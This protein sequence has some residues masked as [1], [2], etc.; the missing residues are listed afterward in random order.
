MKLHVQM[1]CL[2]GMM[3]VVLHWLH[4]VWVWLINWMIEWVVFIF[5]HFSSFCF[6]SSYFHY[7]LTLRLV[8]RCDWLIWHRLYQ[9]IIISPPKLSFHHPIF[10]WFYTATLQ[11]STSS[12]L[13]FI[14]SPHF[15]LWFLIFIFLH[16][17]YSY[18]HATPSNYQLSTTP[19]N[20]LWMSVKTKLPSKPTPL[21]TLISI[22]SVS[23]WKRTTS[24]VPR[25]MP[26]T[27]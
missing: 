23:T 20:A 27:H 19:A 1:T 5:L 7:T 26:S 11:L 10:V 9:I 24:I 8:D 22:H 15:P 25:Q 4:W 13:F 12:Y 17:P 18:H 14:H 3:F 16:L 6:S 21:S 2:N